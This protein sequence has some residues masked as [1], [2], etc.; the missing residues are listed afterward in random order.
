MTR[1]FKSLVLAGIFAISA[2]MAQAQ[3]AQQTTQTGTRLDASQFMQGAA[4]GATSCSTVNQTAAN[5]TVTITPPAGQYVYIT[6]IFVDITANITGTTQV[7]TAS[8]TNVT[9]GPFFSLATII[10]TAGANGTFRQIAENYPIPL[11]ST[12]PGTAVT[13]VPS[14]AGFT[15][16][17]I[18]PRITGYFAP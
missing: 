9:G 7:A 5:N 10:P 2:T 18:C 8:M 14:A 13:W 15:N 6:G 17:I 12:A 1:F 3:V 4:G 11:R 16:T